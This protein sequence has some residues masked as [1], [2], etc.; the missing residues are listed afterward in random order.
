MASKKKWLSV[1]AATASAALVLGGCASTESESGA[2]ESAGSSGGSGQKVL[3]FWAFGDMG[4][5]DFIAEY[6]AANPGIKIEMKVSDF[7]PHHQGLLT[8]LDS[9]T[10]DIAAIEVGYSSLFKSV[11]NKFV[12]LREYGA[13]DLEADFLDWRW[14]QGVDLDGRVFGIPTDVGPM[15]VC[16]RADLFE[17]AG[18]PS[19]RDEVSALWPT[20]EDFISTGEE[21]VAATGNSFISSTGYIW[22]AVKNQ[23]DEKFYS[24]DGSSLVYETNPQI[25]RAWDLSVAATPIAANIGDWTADWNAGMNNGAYAAITCPAWM[26]GYIQ[27]Q[28]PDLSGLW[29][30]ASLPEGGGNWGGSQLVVPARAKY[31]AEAAAFIKYVLSAEKQL[32]LFKSSGQ[33]PSIVSAYSDPS[34]LAFENE[35]F[36]NAPIGKIFAEGVATLQPIYEGPK[37]RVIDSEFGSALGRVAN[38]EQ[39]SKEAYDSAIEAIKR[40]VG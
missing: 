29:D 1:A 27:G 5:G 39:T 25:K 22:N 6:E 3:Q 7:D 9:T 40:D 10:P 36:N 30:V 12:D 15:A 2:G 37:E 32:E 19:Q 13:G 23:S 33:L 34:V 11:A 8:S 38:G 4:L 26:M 17:A 28:A 31:P 35:Y 16:Y 20:W 18:L 14:A 21:Y 24:A